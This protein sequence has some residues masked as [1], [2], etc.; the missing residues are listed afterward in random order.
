MYSVDVFS[1]FA[2]RRD[3]SRPSM[4]MSD[5]GSRPMTYSLLVSGYSRPSSGPLSAFSVGVPT[6]LSR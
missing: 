4:T 1:I 6:P 5:S 3:T 2:C